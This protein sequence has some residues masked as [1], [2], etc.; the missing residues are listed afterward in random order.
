MSAPSA[1]PDTRQR[2][3]AFATEGGYAA[4]I[5]RYERLVGWVL[6]T[7]LGALLLVLSL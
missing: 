4:Q 6:W 7:G 2:P 1:D 3:L 5:T